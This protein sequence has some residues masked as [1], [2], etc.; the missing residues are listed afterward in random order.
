MQKWS[1]TLSKSAFVRGIQCHKSLY[2]KKY[3]PEL[4]VG[5]PIKVTTQ[6]RNYQN[7]VFI[8]DIIH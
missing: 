3:H 2:L 4:E 8:R 1:P 7:Y 6:G 5:R